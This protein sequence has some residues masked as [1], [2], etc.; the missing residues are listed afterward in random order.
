MGWLCR[1]KNCWPFGRDSILLKRLILYWNTIRFLKPVQIYGR[2]WFHLTRPKNLSIFEV[3]LR[4]SRSK[5]IDQPVK[6][7]RLISPK[8]FSLLESERGFSALDWQAPDIEKLWLY[9]LHYFDFLHGDNSQNQTSWQRD[10]I[11]DWIDQ[12]P[13]H[14][15]IGWDPYPTSQRIVNW[16]KWA[17]NGN[18]LERA[19][20]K[21]LNLQSEW[22]SRRIEWHIRGNHLLANAK[23]L[24]F[25][26]LFMK[27]RRCSEWFNIGVKILIEEM[28]EQILP[29]GGH[30]ERSTMYQALVLEDLLDLINLIQVYQVENP[31]L[32]ELREVLTSK[33]VQMFEWLKIMIHPD[34]QVADFNDSIKKVAPDLTELIE[35]G[36]KLSLKFSEIKD[37]S[38]ILPSS[39]YARLSNQNKSAI[40]FLDVG[41]I[42]PDYLPGH[43]HA[44][45]L[46]FE[47]SI[48]GKRVVV[49][50][51]TSTYEEGPQRQF[52]R[53]TSAHSTLQIDNL[54]SSEIWSSFRVG[55]RAKPM[56]F[57]K[58]LSKHRQWVCC[59]HDGYQ[60]RL[61]GR[62][63]HQR[64]WELTEN[65]LLIFDEVI[66]K[67]K[68]ESVVRFLFHPDIQLIE[69]K[70]KKVWSLNKDGTQL[71]LFEIES[72]EG[73]VKEST[74]A[75]GFGKV[76]KTS[77]IEIQVEN[78]ANEC[79]S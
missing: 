52:E 18:E 19:E 31:I 2:I 45:T 62:P 63:I 79:E 11:K 55:K 26:G 36:T 70:D 16:I 60:S 14:K 8:T 41:P 9:N 25:A 13:P 43:G 49:N 69:K 33:S 51:G 59:S 30:F 74:Y 71:A 61:S 5:W 21:S 65:E 54:D 34:G 23:A 76:K 46:S 27:G 7:S 58:S 75:V 64:S 20:L 35:Y 78:G 17:L 40:A 24:V 37:D 67:S 57:K 53:S 66:S 3:E 38:R 50:A 1:G 12:N 6:R 10:L 28:D 22:L 15:G 77:F 68:N 72:G 44:D 56:N 47:L 4:K 48:H 39:G 32:I 73:K 42:G 29:D